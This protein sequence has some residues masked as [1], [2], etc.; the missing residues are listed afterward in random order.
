LLSNALRYT[1]GGGRVA[2]VVE[3]QGEDLVFRVRDSGI[4]VAPEHLPHVFE[5]FYRVEKSRSRAAGGSGIGL[6]IARAL[7][8]A[9]GGRIW[10]E[11]PGPGQGATF[12]FTLP[13]APAFSFPRR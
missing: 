12:S 4:G 3:R 7:V 10:A 1:P 2:V 9:M 5:R 11:S 8:E 6:T 13:A